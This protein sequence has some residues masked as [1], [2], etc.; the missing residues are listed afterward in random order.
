MLPEIVLNKLQ[1]ICSDNAALPSSY[2]VSGELARVGD[3][4]IAFG[5]I[6]DVWDGTY[7]DKEVSIK[8]L[9]VQT[10][11]F[12]VLKKVRV[13]DHVYLSRVFTNTSSR[14]C[15]CGKG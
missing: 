8:S 4:P 5:A 15:W 1:T 9:R 3:G 14:S 13:L 10:K 11:N 6:V 7:R 2:I 12:E